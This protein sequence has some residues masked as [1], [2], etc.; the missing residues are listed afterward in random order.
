MNHRTSQRLGRRSVLSVL[1]I[2]VLAG[3]LT[4]T[5]AQESQEDRSII[6]FVGPDSLHVYIPDGITSSNTKYG[7]KHSN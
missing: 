6:I 2:V 4:T 5:Q 7:K 1:I 3:I